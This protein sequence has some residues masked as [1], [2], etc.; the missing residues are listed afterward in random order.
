MEALE[1]EGQA[2]QEPLASGG[3]F[4]PQRELP[5]AKHFRDDAQDG[6]DRLRACAINRF[7]HGCRERVGHPNLGGGVLRRWVGLRC[8]AFLPTLVVGFAARV[9]GGLDVPIG[10][11]LQRRGAPVAMIQRRRVGRVRLTAPRAVAGVQGREGEQGHAVHHE[12]GQVLRRQAVVQAHPQIARRVVV[13]GLE[14]STHAHYCTPM[15]RT[16]SLLLSDKLLGLFL[17]VECSKGSLNNNFPFSSQSPAWKGGSKSG[18]KRLLRR[19]GQKIVDLCCSVRSLLCRA[20]SLNKGRSLTSPK[21]SIAYH[22]VQTHGAHGEAGAVGSCNH[23]MS[24]VTLP[25][26][27]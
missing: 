20:P 13:R 11:R 15:G 3:H 5:E 17:S 9:D 18:T 4:P 27:P 6:L 21:W 22:I 26:P 1:I 10:A 2:H 7:T 25:L 16:E 12:A 8:E 14:C 24:D 19:H 23:C